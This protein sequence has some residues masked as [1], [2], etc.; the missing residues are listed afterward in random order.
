MTFGKIMKTI[1]DSKK[2]GMVLIIAGLIVWL[3]AIRF[4]PMSKPIGF[5]IIHGI[6]ALA[7]LIIA[8]FIP[9]REERQFVSRQSVLAGMGLLVW[10]GSSK[11]HMIPMFAWV[12][13]SLWWEIVFI[14]AGPLVLAFGSYSI[15]MFTYRRFRQ[16]GFRNIQRAEQAAASNRY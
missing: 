15:A 6:G 1:I 10:M 5:V 12:K 4:V 14:L 16:A 13:G 3:A 2:G 9:E 8:A 7:F 11:I